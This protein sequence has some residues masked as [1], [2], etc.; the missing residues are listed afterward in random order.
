MQ[1]APG[2]H[3]FKAFTANISR[4]DS[5]IACFG[6]HIILDD[7]SMVQGDH[8]TEELGEPNQSDSTEG[9][10][11]TLNNRGTTPEIGSTPMAEPNQS[12][13]I[14][15]FEAFEANLPQQDYKQEESQLDNPTHELL[16]WHYK[17]GHESFNHL[18]WMAKA[19]ILPRRLATCQVPQC[20]ACYYGKASR[21]PWREKW[22]AN[23][24]K[25]AAATVLGQIV[26]VDQMQSTVPGLV[27]QIKGILT[28]QWYHLWIS[29]VV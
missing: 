23:K 29:S 21:R 8:I 15:D 10:P 14:E 17:L 6:A 19:G 2:F 26:S 4:E 20:A 13:L 28:R 7:E 22:S 5:H 24:N 9:D 16:C 18:Q 12:H 11:Q 25:I 3:Q 27:G 1:S